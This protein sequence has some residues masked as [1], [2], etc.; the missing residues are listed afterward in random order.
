ML[1]SRCLLTTY[2]VGPGLAYTSVGAVPW[3]DLAA[4]DTVSIHY[5][6]EP[7]RELILISAQGTAEAPVR[8]QGIAGPNGERPII[9]GE[10]A[11]LGPNLHYTYSGLPMRG[12]LTISLGADD[13]YGEKPSYIEISGLELRNAHLGNSFTRPDNTVSD[14]LSNAAGIYVER[15]EHITIRDCEIDHNSNG[16]FVASGDEEALQ[17]RE[18]LVQGNFIHDNGNVG[19]DR[20]H[21]VYTEAIG[22][23]FEDNHFAPL[24]PGA[25]GNNIKDRS[26][27]LVVRNNWI[28]GG[29]HLLDLVDPE[30][31]SNQAVVDPRFQQTF[32]YGNVLLNTAG[33]GNASNLIHYGGDSGDTSIYRKGTLYFYQNTVVIHGSRTGPNARWFTDLFHFDTNQQI[34]DI[35]NNIFY[36]AGDPDAPEGTEPTG[37]ALFNNIAG[38][39]HFE[40]NWISPNWHTWRNDDAPAGASVTGTNNF[41]TNAAN[42]PGFSDLSSYDLWLT[43]FSDAI[44]QSGPFAAVVIGQQEPTRQYV[45]H[46]SHTDRIV[47]GDALDLGAFEGAAAVGPG[48]LQFQF[49]AQTVLEDAGVAHVIVKRNGGTSGAVT[50][51]F[52]TLPGT[53][54]ADTEFTAT[55]GTLQFADGQ[56]TAQIDVT[57]L[58]NLFSGPNKSLQL[59]LSD[60]TDGAALG[61]TTTLTLTIQNDEPQ[62]P[63]PSPV[64]FSQST[65]SATTASGQLIVNITRDGDLSL[66]GQVKVATQSKSA[67]AGIHFIALSQTIQFAPGQATQ[68]VTIQIL[69]QPLDKGKK[70]FR[71]L[72]SNASGV[73]L[74]R[75]AQAAKVAIS[76][77]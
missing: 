13:S 35:R 43:S 76:A 64:G 39:A 42:D 18:I 10:D 11:V 70:I 62:V 8:V 26:A 5:R 24:L 40:T 1:E 57:I 17:S 53:A 63:G 45:L 60:P 14:Y 3:D 4:G 37:F 51:H 25:G 72:L 49:A 73:T 32:V 28:E 38:T 27:G 47:Q 34:A 50:V 55:S 30:G 69:N 16:L 7:Y 41:I 75:K 46:Q 52:A 67:K 2:E 19:S 33:P 15:G 36:A 12:L 58:D 9:D 66:A 22:I 31:S 20:H 71:L 21:N 6:P 29:A 65:Y 77:D 68:Q 54:H 59:Q 23:T 48:N 44:D 56:S 61:A 74:N